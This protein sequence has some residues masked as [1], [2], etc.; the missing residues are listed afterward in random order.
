MNDSLNLLASGRRS[1]IAWFAIVLVAVCMSPLAAQS[2]LDSRRFHYPPTA[3]QEI[4]DDYHGTRVADPYRWLEDVESDQ[5]S[6]WVTSQN[7]LTFDYLA[8][9]PQR[10]TIRQRLTEVWN[11]ERYGFPVQRKE[12]FFYTHNN[13]LQNQSSI[14]VADGI[15]AEKR[16]L[17][18]ANGLSQDGTIALAEWKL[19][20]DGSWLAYAI[21][22]GGSDWRTWRVRDT[23]TGRDTADEIRWVKFSEVAWTADN[24]GF[25]YS[26]YDEPSAKQELSGANYFQK[27]YYHKLGSPQSEDRLVYRRDD[28]K[29]WG[30]RSEVTE[31]GR[32]LIISVWR[33]TENNNQVFYIELTDA[34]WTVRE[35][36]AG[37]D[38]EYTFLGN[39]GS[40]FYFMTDSAAPRRRVIAVDITR[41][42]RAAWKEIV[43]QALETIQSAS[44]FQ[45]QLLLTYLKDA[46]HEVRLFGINGQSRGLLELPGLGTVDGFQGKRSSQ[47]I[48]YSFTNYITPP[49]VYRY[50]ISGGESSL[51]RAPK[52]PFNAADFTTERIFY[53]SRDG[54]RIPMIVSS[55]KGILKDGNNRTLL[56]GYGGFDISIT[57][58]FSPAHLVW[59]ELGGIYAVP[60]LRG[61]GEYGRAWHE[62]GMLDKKQNVF[63]DYIAAAEH[64]IAQKYTCSSQLAISGRSNGG[65]LVGASMTQRPDLF[66]VALPAVGVMDMLRYHKFTIGWAWVNEFGSS[67]D[68]R[69]FAHIYKYSPLHNLREG[70]CYPATLVTTADRDDRVVPGHSFKFAAR[71]QACQSCN[72]PALIRIET[73]AGHGAGTP[74]SKLIDQAA[75]TWAF[76]LDNLEK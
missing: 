47:Q 40:L 57:P 59:M 44:L 41:S 36:V 68:A 5:T 66:A 34:T 42:A 76:V 14:Y 3:K 56:Y 25:F 29:E 62:A 16:M 8:G 33:G 50:E 22:D 53:E 21:A 30:F 19:S 37:F 43:P 35:L 32:F 72:K 63:D 49:T 11:F 74:V 75:D 46:C 48:F 70:T 73:R 65:L 61:G 28:F 7:K 31:D 27:L 67:D 39:D 51:W 9:L 2:K 38:A 17:L 52:L 55:K 1:Q 58:N 18:D 69:H 24:K 54:T 20:D 15:H 26:R 6:R 60:N 4:L 64:L 13:G 71:L 10:T 23:R 45:D 12:Q